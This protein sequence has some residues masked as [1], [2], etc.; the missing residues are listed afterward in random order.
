MWYLG[1]PGD[2]RPLVCPDTNISI[3]KRRYGGVQ[4]GISGARTVDVTGFR[5]DYVFSFSFME[6]SEWSWLEALHTRHVRGPFWLIN[7]MR[8]NRLSTRA[9]TL[10]R[11]FNSNAGI[12]MQGG[13]TQLVADWP[14]AANPGALSMRWYSRTNPSVMYF[15]RD[16]RFPVFP[17]EQVTRS[18]YMRSS[19]GTID[20]QSRIQWY[21]KDG[22]AIVS[23]P[24]TTHSVGTSWTRFSQ[25]TTAPADAVT[26]LF[27]LYTESITNDL[28]VAAPQLNNGA[29]AL[30]WEQGGGAPLVHVDQLETT[31]PRY[32]LSSVN[33]TLLE[34]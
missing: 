5:D 21:K 3:I 4:V 34:A 20:V 6:P 33:L 31:S 18:V 28:F 29:T 32:P 26:G 16:I 17:T 15:D 25:T 27:H 9:T 22:T 7:P 24:T 10:D 30:A 14:S 19:A 8:N 2:L 1:P 11:S 12:T 13:S 23:I